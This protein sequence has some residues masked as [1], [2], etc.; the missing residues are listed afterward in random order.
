MNEQR[1]PRYQ[2]AISAIASRESPAVLGE[3]LARCIKAARLQNAPVLINILVNGNPELFDQIVD[4]SST[5]CAHASETTDVNI[6]HF[7]R[8][9][10]SSTINEYIYSFYD[11]AH[12]HI[13]I[14]GY[15]W[16]HPDT[17]SKIAQAYAS[18]PFLAATGVPSQ[19][20]S[21]KK[22]REQMLREG[23]LHG[24]MCIL[25]NESLKR[26]VSHSFKVPAFLYRSDGL[27]GAIIN[28]NFSPA[29]NAWNAKAVRVIPELTWS[30]PRNP[31]FH[32]KALI[33]YF[34]RRLRQLQGDI[35]NRAIK[36][37]LAQQ[38]IAIA[39]LPDTTYALCA[40][41]LHRESFSP[42][43]YLLSPLRGYTQSRLLKKHAQ[44]DRKPLGTNSRKCHAVS[45]N[46]A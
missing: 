9:D 41:Q 20:R 38:K 32:P 13:L 23:G 33:A 2:H 19:G 3:T 10:K 16:V 46:K 14:D 35:E 17:L 12:L 24:N 15:V 40:E 36:R 6:C 42:L 43:S 5:I 27:L 7:E 28:F 37:L 30:I 45:H 18:D 8:G 1:H 11:T 39:G 21:A 25:A 31:L 29:S 22:V 4:S 44:V 34:K 26:M